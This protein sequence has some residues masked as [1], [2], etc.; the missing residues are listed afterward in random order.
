MVLNL[1]VN[2]PKGETWHSKNLPWLSCGATNSKHFI[3][4][5][6]HHVFYDVILQFQL[7]SF[8][9]QTID[10]LVQLVQSNRWEGS[11]CYLVIK[12]YFPGILRDMGLIVC[13]LASHFQVTK[14]LFMMMIW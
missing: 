1:W 12:Q 2:T 4:L 13:G 14:A 5:H 11:I 9:S 6:Y 3:L 7:N 8:V 10:S